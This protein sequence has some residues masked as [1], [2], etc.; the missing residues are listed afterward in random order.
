MHMS[1]VYISRFSQVILWAHTPNEVLTEPKKHYTGINIHY[2]YYVKVRV[3]KLNVYD[4]IFC[5][6]LISDF[7]ILS[8]LPK[9]RT[10]E[11]QHAS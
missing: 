1:A 9:L 5:E 11:C 2:S 10:A 8:L 7:N 6:R 3:R 4:F